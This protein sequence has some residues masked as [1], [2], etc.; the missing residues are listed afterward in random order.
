MTTHFICTGTCSGLA[1][2]PGVCLADGCTKKGQPLLECSCKDGV[3]QKYGEVSET[4]P[5]EA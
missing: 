2:T 4:K 5:Q 3:H 1:D